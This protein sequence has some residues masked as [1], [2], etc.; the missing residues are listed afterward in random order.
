VLAETIEGI[1]GGG[2][3]QD[4][5]ED[6]DERLLRR[7]QQRQQALGY[8]KSDREVGDSANPESKYR[9]TL[10]SGGGH[11]D[12]TS[13]TRQVTCYTGYETTLRTKHIAVKSEISKG[14]TDC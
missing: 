10:D 7:L 9:E 13:G 11:D 4:E 1:R 6:M 8:R 14:S 12:A 5:F 2:H 3:L